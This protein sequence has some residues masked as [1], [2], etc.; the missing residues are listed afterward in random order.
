MALMYEE[1]TKYRTEVGSVLTMILLIAVLTFMATKVRVLVS[2]DSD[3]NY[4]QFSTDRDLYDPDEL[5]NLHD[6]QFQFAFGNLDE[7]IPIK[8][9]RWA[10][11][12]K[13][14][15]WHEG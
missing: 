1:D 14:N 8:Y 13:Q 11:T 2:Q 5:I 6:N 12:Y 10:V 3:Q 4:Y 9:G 15:T 7:E